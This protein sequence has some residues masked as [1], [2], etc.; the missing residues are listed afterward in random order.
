MMKGLTDYLSASK[1]TFKI[2]APTG[3]A[4]KVISQKTKHKA[5]TIHKTIYSSTD[6]REFKVNDEDG[7]E[8]FKFYY[9]LKHNEDP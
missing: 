3:R 7:T 8:T 1:R 5:Y 2:A 9:D 6:L 4:A